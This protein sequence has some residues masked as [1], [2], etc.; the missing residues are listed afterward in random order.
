MVLM[1]VK[2]Q[3]AFLKKHVHVR[4]A[5]TIP[6][7]HTWDEGKDITD[8]LV[9]IFSDLYHCMLGVGYMIHESLIIFKYSDLEIY[10]SHIPDNL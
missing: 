5:H 4:Q 2:F 10:H 1:S 6:C 7:P 8:A 3:N 9:H